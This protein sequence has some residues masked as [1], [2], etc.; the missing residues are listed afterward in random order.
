M[1]GVQIVVATNPDL[2][3]TSQLDVECLADGVTDPNDDVVTL[4]YQWYINGSLQTDIN[5]DTLTAP[6]SVGDEIGCQITPND[7]FDDGDMLETSIVIPNSLP[8][9][10]SIEIDPN[11]DVEANAT[12]TCTV[13]AYDTDDGVLVGQYEWLDGDGNSAGIGNTLMLV[14]NSNRPGRDYVYCTSIRQ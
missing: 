12:L 7:G 6:F 3:F 13:D 14:P 2:P 1:E 10:F 8:E 4:S 11:S 9:I 5:S